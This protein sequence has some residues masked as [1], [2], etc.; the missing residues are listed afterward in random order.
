M[1]A[2]GCVKFE[3]FFVLAI[4]TIATMPAYIASEIAGRCSND[5]GQVWVE[6]ESAR[7]RTGAIDSP[8]IDWIRTAIR[9]LPQAECLQRFDPH[10]QQL[11]CLPA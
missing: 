1:R 10:Q 7:S 9:H 3:W 11:I 5:H 6:W 8:L 4:Q 2:G